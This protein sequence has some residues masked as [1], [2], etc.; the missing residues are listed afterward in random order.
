MKNIYWSKLTKKQKI[1]YYF[2]YYFGWTMLAV[3]AVLFVAFYAWQVLSQEKPDLYVISIGNSYPDDEVTDTLIS[4]LKNT[5]NDTDGSGAVYIDYNTILDNIATVG[6]ESNYM[7]QQKYLT[8]LGEG[9]SRVILMDKDHYEAT[10]V[11]DQFDGFLTDLTG[12]SD[13]VYKRY[14][15]PVEATSIY[16]EDGLDFYSDYYIVLTQIGGNKKEKGINIERFNTGKQ[17][18]ADILK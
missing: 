3:V 13:S 7:Y 11:D 17:L 6:A 9:H 18:I 5:A 14:A 12:I 15:I 4:Y 2:Q 10:L 1:D 8:L 16:D